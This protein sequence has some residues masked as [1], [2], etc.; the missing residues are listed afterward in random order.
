MEVV[1]DLMEE[2]VEIVGKQE[3]QYSNHTQEVI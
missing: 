3:T 2:I 1:V